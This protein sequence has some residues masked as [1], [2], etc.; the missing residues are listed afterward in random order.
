M[1]IISIWALNWCFGQWFPLT[2]IFYSRVIW[3]IINAMLDE[4]D[5]KESRVSITQ[6]FY[7]QSITSGEST[8]SCCPQGQPNRMN[9]VRKIFMFV[10]RF[11][12]NQISW[13]RCETENNR[14]NKS[15]KMKGI[16]VFRD[17][18]TQVRRYYKL[19]TFANVTSEPQFEPTFWNMAAHCE[20]IVLLI[21]KFSQGMSNWTER[22]A[23][24]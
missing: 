19:N 23:F 1:V 9:P 18:V 14:R 15:D 6:D 8:C 2:F 13:C 17:S 22:I 10:S 7:G 24:P 5:G 20:N 3:Y 16:H 12:W 4:E 11:G 21:L